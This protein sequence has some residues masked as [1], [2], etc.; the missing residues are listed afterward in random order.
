MPALKPLSFVGSS[1]KELRA[2]PDA[3]RREAGHQLFQIQRGD[4]PDDWRPMRIV[5]SGV[6]EIRLQHEGQYRLFYVTNVRG[7][8]NVLRAFRKKTQKTSKMDIEIARHR[9][10]QIQEK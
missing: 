4:E 5:G 1:L 9:L 8:I 6:R 10:R 7:G 2:F 3:P